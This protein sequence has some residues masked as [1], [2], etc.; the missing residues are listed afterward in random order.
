MTTEASE[1]GSWY[2]R[3]AVVLALGMGRSRHLL[4]IVLA[5]TVPAAGVG[6]ASAAAAILYV[7]DAKDY[8]V[9][10]KVDGQERYALAF[11]GTAGCYF[12]E[13]HE[14]VGPTT[15]SV[16]SSPLPMR[17]TPRGY[18]AGELGFPAARVVAN[19]HRDHATGSYYYE[20]SEENF[21][22]ETRGGRFEA[23]RYAPIGSPEAGA[24]K[25]GETRVYYAEEDP[26]AIYLR[27]RGDELSGIRGTFVPRCPVGRDGKSGEPTSLFR[28]PVFVKVGKQGGFRGHVAMSGRLAGGGT[29]KETA[30]IAGQAKSGGVAGSYT[31]VRKT[32]S[33]P[34]P[35]RC[36]T[37]PVPFSAPRYLPA[38]G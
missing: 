37:G 11:A 1:A 19:F 30:T 23:A 29:F 8:S 24:P 26:V 32:T 13:P 22:C 25:N 5:L 35:R 14:N 18:V 27:G 17:E 6:A 36:V 33:G 2:F 4:L 31:R 15:F 38:A 16:F 20:E 7:G 3:R 21:H 34:R 10:F 12:T 9:A 28:N